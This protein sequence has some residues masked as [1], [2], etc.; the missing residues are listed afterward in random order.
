MGHMLN[1]SMVANWATFL[2]FSAGVNDSLSVEENEIRF[3][4][5]SFS[6]PNL[7]QTPLKALIH[8]TPNFY[9]T[10]FHPTGG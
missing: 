9:E 7:S 6:K 3:S 1:H 10:N 8:K 5:S 4:F 2:I